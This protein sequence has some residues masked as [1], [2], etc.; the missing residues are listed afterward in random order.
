MQT[1]GEIYRNSTTQPQKGWRICRQHNSELVYRDFIKRLQMYCFPNDFILSDE[2]KNIIG[3]I[4]LWFSNDDRFKGDSKKGILLRGNCGTGK[5]MIVET[6]LEVIKQGDNKIALLINVRDLQDLY[7]KN[8]IEKI[9]ILK[10]RFLIII[11]DLGV[12]NTDIKNYGNLLEPFN[13]LFDYRYRNRM[14]TIL[15]TNLTPERIK[16][17][18]GDRILDRF[19]EMFNE[20]LFTIK[21]MRQ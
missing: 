2:T 19:K 13:D 12:E 8:D 16:E 20:Y 6:L 15:T 17:L 5:T 1:I 18:Y 9:E 21:S 14:E 10:K 7:I 11:D 4:T 3:Q